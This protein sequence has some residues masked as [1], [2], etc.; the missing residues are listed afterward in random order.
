M[1]IRS[2]AFL[3]AIVF[4]ASTYSQ[5]LV[6][7]RDSEGNVVNGT[8]VHYPGLPTDASNVVHLFAELSGSV[9]TEVNLRRY[10]VWPI[11]GSSNYFCWGVC[12]LSVASGVNPS[13]LSQHYVQME[14]DVEVNNFGAYYEPNNNSG[15]AR[16]RYVWFNTATPDGPD[17]SWVDIDF[18]GT[19]G[20]SENT[21]TTIALDAWPNPSAGADV[22]IDFTLDKL[23]Q[24]TEIALYN[25]LG[26]SVRR[27]SVA[28]G[29]GRITIA[30]N[31]LGSGVYFANI[32]RGGRMLA[33]RRVVISR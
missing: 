29:Q 10:E 18:G 4:S 15:T 2:A 20:L 31:G 9:A 25:V 28:A 14:P 5:G 1:I 30:T 16:F 27:Q 7:L 13:W 24:G 11:A 17:S 3:T 26:E 33:T 6:V 12:Y 19:V 32:E 8:V 22:S 23:G 21:G